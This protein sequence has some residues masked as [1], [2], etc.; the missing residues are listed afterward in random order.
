MRQPLIAHAKNIESGFFVAEAA[1]LALAVGRCEAFRRQIASGVD[2]QWRP[3]REGKQARIG[4]ARPCR[5]APLGR[6]GRFPAL[7]YAPKRRGDET[8][9]CR[10]A[11]KP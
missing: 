5:T 7:P 9:A 11:S 8:P 4:E 3:P 6:S 10:T 2:S 1:A